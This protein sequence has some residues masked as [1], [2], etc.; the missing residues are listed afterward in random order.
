MSEF[1]IAAFATA[2]VSADLISTLAYK[3]SI[4]AALASFSTTVS[5][6]AAFAAAKSP[7]TFSCFLASTSAS[8]EAYAALALTPAALI[9]APFALKSADAAS[10]A[11]LVVD[12]PYSGL[13][14]FGA[15]ITMFSLL[16]PGFA[17]PPSIAEA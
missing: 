13:K 1:A 8:I 16:S 15:A 10:P 4:F 9:A 2:A 6:L 17:S 3:A 12:T 5:G 11:L 14:D 7:T